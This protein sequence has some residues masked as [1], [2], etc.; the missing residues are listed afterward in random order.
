MI[1]DDHQFYWQLSDRPQAVSIHMLLHSG[2]ISLIELDHS[3]IMIS[4]AIRCVS[5][6]LGDQ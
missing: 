3:Q 5:M 1:V 6:P 2:R 4:P